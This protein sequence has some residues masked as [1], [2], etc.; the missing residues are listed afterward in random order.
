YFYALATHWPVFARYALPL[1]PMMCLLSSLAVLDAIA[2]VRN[3]VPRLA[4]REYAWGPAVVIAFVLFWAPVVVTV[5]WLDQ[6]KR[7]DTRELAVRWLRSAAAP[8]SRIAVESS[9]PTYLEEAAFRV[10]PTELL[11]DH[12]PDW[13]PAHADYLIISSANP[14]RYAPYIAEGR[15]VFQIAPAADRWGPPITIVKLD[16]PKDGAH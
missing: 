1:L 5:K 4:R 14:P 15:T 10:V 6:Q 2:L 13:Y 7:A 3:R 11:V 9:G 12:P 16:A 8:Q